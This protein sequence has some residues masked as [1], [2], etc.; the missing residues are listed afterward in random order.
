MPIPTFK[1]AEVH[2][3]ASFDPG[4]QRYT[5]RYTVSNPA[6]NTGEIWDIQ[7]DVTTHVSPSYRSPAFNSSGL[8]IQKGG[9]GQEPFD[10]EVADLSPLALPAGMTIVAFGQ[11]APR[12]WNGGL[13]RNGFAYFFSGEPADHI[14]PGQTLSGF[15]L[16]SPGMP[17]IRKMEVHPKWTYVVKDLEVVDADELVAATKVEENLT[18]HT[19]TLGPSAQ[20]PGTS[21]H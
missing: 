17:T 2:A 20:I 10:K 7:L 8:T 11:Q 5:Y 18:V 3:E 21:P 9:V 4:T 1:A 16:L 15:A 19:S 13:M 14:L 12:G 6:S